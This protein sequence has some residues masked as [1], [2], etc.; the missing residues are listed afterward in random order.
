MSD[1][2]RP[3]EAVKK[4]LLKVAGQLAENGFWGNEELDRLSEATARL[5]TSYIHL[6][7]AGE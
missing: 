5:T 6:K 7:A 4:A 2:A 1:E 3:S